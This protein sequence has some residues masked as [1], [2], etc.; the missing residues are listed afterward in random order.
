MIVIDSF[1]CMNCSPPIEGLRSKERSC[2]CCARSCSVEVWTL[3]LGELQTSNRSA[4]ISEHYTL[5]NTPN[6]LFA[7]PNSVLLVSLTFMSL[8]FLLSKKFEGEKL[9]PLLQFDSW[10][11]I[12]Y[13]VD[14]LAMY[15]IGFLY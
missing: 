11:F 4:G 7:I 13:F 15:Y 14:K 5:G 1:S 9:L 6:C 8:S 10:L 12:S 2:H 3:S